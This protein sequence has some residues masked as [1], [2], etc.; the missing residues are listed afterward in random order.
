[1]GTRKMFH[2]GKNGVGKHER[3]GDG[4]EKQAHGIGCGLVSVHH[5]TSMMNGGPNIGQL[6]PFSTLTCEH[7]VLVALPRSSAWVFL[8]IRS[9]SVQ[10]SV[11]RQRSGWSQ[12][13]CVVLVVLVS[14][15]THRSTRPALPPKKSSVSIKPNYSG[16]VAKPCDNVCKIRYRLTIHGLSTMIDSDTFMRRRKT[17]SGHRHPVEDIPAPPARRSVA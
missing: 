3:Y 13:C 4:M 1:M 5:S 15:K 6:K 11:T 9:G 8:I 7:C 16:R 17:Y 14:R 2:A 10:R 12:A